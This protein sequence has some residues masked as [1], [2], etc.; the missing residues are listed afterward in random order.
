VTSDELDRSSL[1]VELN[2]FRDLFGSQMS[3][4]TGETLPADV[5]LNGA[6]IDLEAFDDDFEGLSSRV[7]GHQLRDFVLVRPT[8][9][10]SFGLRNC[11]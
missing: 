5:L 7:G 11:L 10:P 4:P 2:S 9:D 3:D 6:L 8:T 1:G